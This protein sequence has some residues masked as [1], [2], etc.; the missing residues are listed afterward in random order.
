MLD[1]AI[2]TVAS[3]LLEGSL[4]SRQNTL[5]Q[6]LLA[7][8]SEIARRGMLGS[9]VAI[10]QYAEASAEEMRE[11]AS[12]LWDSLQRALAAMPPQPRPTLKDDVTAAFNSLFRTK[13]DSINAEMRARVTGPGMGMRDQGTADLQTKYQAMVLQYGAEISLWAAARERSSPG[14]S[15]PQATYI[16]HAP[17]AS[18]QTGPGASAQVV[19]TI[20]SEDVAR[21]VEQ[22]RELARQIGELQSLNEQTRG[23]G[24]NLTSDIQAELQTPQPSRT[25]LRGL[26]YGL[27]EFVQA[28]GAAP[29]AYGTL[30]S[31]ATALGLM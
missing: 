31:M 25:K 11:V 29:A 7:R 14:S 16:F 4:G 23:E 12:I 2:V 30:Q 1:Q 18:V 13:F 27:S 21:I 5:G 19:Q 10:W 3:D 20:G 15:P 22:L 8:Q 26:F 17:V 6:K 28:L 9:S 24:V